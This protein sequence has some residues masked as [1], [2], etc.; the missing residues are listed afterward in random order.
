ME[1]RA[2]TL[3]ERLGFLD[4]DRR[5]FK[6]DEIQIWVYRNFPSILKQ[7]L[8][9]VQ[10]DDAV[11]LDLRLEYPIADQTYNRNYIVGFVDVYCRRLSVGVEVKTEIPRVGDLIRQIQFYKRYSTMSWIVVSPDDENAEILKE[12]G[13]YFYKYKAAVD[14]QL[15]LFERIEYLEG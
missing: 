14:K 8:P 10:V 5:K 3:I 13:I 9:L 7:V 6:H 4:T 2:K 15:R 11:P 1:P 12:Q